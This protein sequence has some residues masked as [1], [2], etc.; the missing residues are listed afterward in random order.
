V[1]VEINYAGRG[2][3]QIREV[4]TSSNNVAAKVVETR[5]EAGRVGY[6]L[7]VSV[8]PAA[9]LGQFADIIENAGDRNA[10]AASRV[11]M[12]LEQRNH[13]PSRDLYLHRHEHR[14]GRSQR[15]DAWQNTSFEER[16][17]NIQKRIDRLVRLGR[18]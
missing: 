17:A 16:K 3:W 15:D 13:E 10:I 14:T 8:A 11:L 9:K 6:Q 4:R 1:R 7:E 5:R 12:M 2:D 18:L